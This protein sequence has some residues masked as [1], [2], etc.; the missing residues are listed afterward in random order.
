[1]GN[2][3]LPAFESNA[4]EQRVA[5]QPNPAFQGLAALQQARQRFFGTLFDAATDIGQQVINTA[6]ANQMTAAQTEYTQAQQQ[7]LLELE[8]EP[9]TSLD[10]RFSTMSPE[11]QLTP[12]LT[13]FNRWKQ[14]Y[15]GENMKKITLPA[16][17]R[18]FE[19]W[20]KEKGFAETEGLTKF[21]ISANR[22]TG[23]VNLAKNLQAAVEAGDRALV[24]EVIDNSEYAGF[25]SRAEAIEA[26]NTNFANIVER[27]AFMKTLSMPAESLPEMTMAVEPPS[28]TRGMVAPGNVDLNKQPVVKNAD[29]TIS[30]VKSISI[31]VETARVGV[32]GSA[33]IPKGQTKATV[34]I[35]TITPDGKEMSNEEAIAEYRKSGLSLGTFRDEASASRYA[36]QL[37][38]KMGE[39]YKPA[40]MGGLEFL[41]DRNNLT[42]IN[43]DGKTEQLSLGQQENLIRKYKVH[44]EEVAKQRDTFYS[45]VHI[46]ADTLEKVDQGIAMLRADRSMLGTQKYEW[47]MRFERARENILSMLN[48]K[49]AAA[50]TAHD[51]WQK[52]NE[53]AVLGK[54]TEF[55]WRRPDEVKLIKETLDREYLQGRISGKFYS[56]QLKAHTIPSTPGYKQG[57]DLLKNKIKGYTPERQERIMAAYDK[58]YR[59]PTRSVAPNEKE[60]AQW[61]TNT[62]DKELQDAI[63]SAYPAYQESQ[64]RGELYGR[65]A[66]DLDQVV[67]FG[68][69]AVEYARRSHPSAALDFGWIDT[70]NT[71]GFGEG[72]VIMMNSTKKIPHAF[73]KEGRELKLYV[74]RE[75]NKGQWTW[76]E[77]PSQRKIQQASTEAKN[78]AIAAQQKL[79]QAA[80]L[81]RGQ[82]REEFAESNVSRLSETQKMQMID[83]INKPWIAPKLLPKIAA[84]LSQSFG[85]A[86]TAADLLLEAKNRGF[87]PADAELPK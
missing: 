15:L 55:A 52:Q 30:S 86:I 45:E 9:V 79:D 43:W 11:E 66:V 1:M 64:Q 70:D 41:A 69:T 17:Q 56:D 50:K 74:G 61:I 20:T 44:L 26:K 53:D 58:F 76:S 39:R 14:G 75:D 35:P 87:I 4:V 78:A 22:A 46:R 54:I 72:Q 31:E 68:P 59:D 2:I 21:D 23:R 33:V 34:L 25:I 5:P 67:G 80:A 18:K 40:E 57:L 51:D 38:Q 49:N 8:K 7:K 73:R 10:P 48:L 81:A 27:E 60:V 42:Y 71:Y 36:A 28:D 84:E 24:I 19:Q 77:V 12:N 13:E 85:Y 6:M 32:V 83:A 37:S 63:Y 16:V 65:V 82:T 62:S 47:E 3:T 29:G